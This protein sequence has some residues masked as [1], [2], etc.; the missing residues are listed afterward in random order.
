MAFQLSSLSDFDL[1]TPVVL[2]LWSSAVYNQTFINKSSFLNMYSKIKLV[3][4]K[5][6]YKLAKLNEKNSEHK[7]YISKNAFNQGTSYFKW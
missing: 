4:G 6:G 1:I 3:V 2:L 5:R 7:M